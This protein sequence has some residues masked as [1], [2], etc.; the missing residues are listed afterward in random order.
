[1]KGEWN[2]ERLWSRY[3]NWKKNDF[4]KMCDKIEFCSKREK[5]KFNPIVCAESYLKEYVHGDIKR[6]LKI[7]AEANSL[8]Y[9]EYMV[10]LITMTGAGATVLGVIVNMYATAFG[11]KEYILFS[12]IFFMLMWQIG[13]RKL[14]NVRTWQKY[15]IVVIEELEMQMNVNTNR[16]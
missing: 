9:N 3:F 12:L 14:K 4:E 16:K 11:L 10:T 7:K 1:M 5:C 2:M 8:S 15:V 6:L 13:L